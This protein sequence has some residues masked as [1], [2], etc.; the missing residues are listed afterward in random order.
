MTVK[1]CVYLEA[2]L[3]AGDHVELVVGQLQGPV[4]PHS[5][6]HT[7]LLRLLH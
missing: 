6:R 7:P 4:D 5:H 3:A 2:R 1:W